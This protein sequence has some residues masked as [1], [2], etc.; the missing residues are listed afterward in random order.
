MQ[1]PPSTINLYMGAS[2]PFYRMTQEQQQQ[3]QQQ[4]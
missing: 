3:Q 2:S 4:Q 1:V